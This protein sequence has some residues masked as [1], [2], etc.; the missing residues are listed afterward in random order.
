MHREILN[1]RQTELLPL[2]A[3]FRREYYLVGGTAIALHI[4]HRRSIDFDLFKQSQ[5]N[6]KKNLDR[7]LDGG[8]P[9]QVTRRVEE[10]MNLI[11]NEVKITFF[12]YPFHVSAKEN[13]EDTFRMPSLLTL[14]AMKA[15]ALGRRSK[16]KDYVDLYF[17]LKDHFSLTEIAGT[18]SEIFGELF[19]EK[20]FRAQ[21]SYFDDV[22]YTEKVDYL[23]ADPPSD[24]DIKSYLTE[25]SLAG[26]G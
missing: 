20:L 9:Y 12:Q 14:A 8:F 10:Q 7:I 11:V 18:A 23:V 25:V 16:W 5:L 6:H 22:D 4:G 15:Y 21:L 19:S 17:L 24:D 26:I 3:K 2:M 13:F 1:G